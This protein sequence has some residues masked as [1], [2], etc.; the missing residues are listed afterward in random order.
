MFRIVTIFLTF[1]IQK[2]IY[3]LY[4]CKRDK[5]FNHNKTPFLH[6][7]TITYLPTLPKTIFASI[8]GGFFLTKRTG[9]ERAL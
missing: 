7:L 5:F 6:T 1:E 8:S 3:T 4:T 9:E 2:S